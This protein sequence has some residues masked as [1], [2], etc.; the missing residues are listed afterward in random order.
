M[1]LMTAYWGM[2][3]ISAIIVGIMMI[4]IG[5]YLLGSTELALLLIIVG[6]IS[7]GVGC[8]MLKYSEKHSKK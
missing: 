8:W 4:L 3:A 6:A 1:S 2:R 7:T 5:F